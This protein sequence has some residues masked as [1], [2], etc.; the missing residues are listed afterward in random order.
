[1][2]NEGGTHVQCPQDKN[3]L[4]TEKYEGD[5]VV[6]RCPACHGFWLDKDE[7]E[8]VQ[9]TLE[10]DYS[11]Q[12]SG[13][14][15]VADAYEMARQKMRPEIRCPKCQQS[16]HAQE[17]AYC[18]QIL[19]DC[20]GKCGGVWLDAGEIKALEQFFEREAGVGSGARKGFFAGLLARLG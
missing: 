7:L 5:V 12:L 14:S 15:V 18:S 4:V 8:S 16:M 3:G 17:Y 11:K 9:H 20:C 6:D 13:L 10:H 19:V 2:K 1:M